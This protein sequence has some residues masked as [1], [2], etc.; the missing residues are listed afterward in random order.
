MLVIGLVLGPSL[1]AILWLSNVCKQCTL[2]VNN[3]NSFQ[4]YI[5]MGDTFAYNRIP[6]IDMT[7]K[8]GPSTNHI[9]N[10]FTTELHV[11]KQQHTPIAN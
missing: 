6:V 7:I 9:T 4:Y 10:M 2:H 1:K 5:I 11:C 8:L 3:N